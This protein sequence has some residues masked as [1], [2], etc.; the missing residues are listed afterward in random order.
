[1]LICFTM[2]LMGTRLPISERALFQRIDR[3]LR[4]SGKKL[5]TSRTTQMETSVGRHYIIDMQR[6]SI[7]R[8]SV[9]LIELGRELGVIQPWEK[10]E[11]E[12]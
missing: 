4:L 12:R 2:E 6:N 8:K 10:L 3:K 1:M 5:G 7:S 11:G 9:D